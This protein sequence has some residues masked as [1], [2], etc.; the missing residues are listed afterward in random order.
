MDTQTNKRAIETIGYKGKKY[1]IDVPIRDLCEAPHQDNKWRKE[2]LEFAIQ[3]RDWVTVE[4]RITNGIRFM[5]LWELDENG[6]R[7]D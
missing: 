6:N 7:V 3:Q 1:E 2:Q 5:W 4:N